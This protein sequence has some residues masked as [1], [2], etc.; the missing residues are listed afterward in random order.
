MLLR[1]PAY[2]VT[3]ALVACAPPETDV[4]NGGSHRS[5][6]W[7]H[8]PAVCAVDEAR[9]YHC[10]ELLPRNS[11][12]PAPPPYSDCPGEDEGHQGELEPVPKVAVFDASY[13]EYI[14]K[15]QPPGHSCCYSWCSRIQLA[16]PRAIDPQERCT[17]ARAMRETYCFDEPES[18]SSI[19]AAAPLD[20]CP[21]AMVPPEGEVFFAPPGVL[22]D[23]RYTMQRRQQGFRECCYAWCSVAPPGMNLSTP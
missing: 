20:H 23:P 13:T 21:A 10:E 11:S 2:L 5:A 18:G 12:L 15:R 16:D 7:S 14:R 1:L 17:H 8:S 19:P 22:L 9:E 3:A 4:E 6:Y